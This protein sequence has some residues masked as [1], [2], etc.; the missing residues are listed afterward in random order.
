MLV[1][2]WL[3]AAAP[4]LPTT[5]AAAAPYD[6]AY[7]AESIPSFVELFAPVAVSVTMRNTGTATW[8]R[9]EGDVFL[10]TQRPQDNYYW[11]IQ[12]NPHGM[13]SGNRVLLPHDVAPAAE[14]TFSFVIKPL[15]CGFTAAAPF[16]FRM[17]SQTHGTFG[18]ETPDPGTTV[19]NAA[20]FVSQQAPSIAPAGARIPASVSFRNT[21][22][23]TW[24]AAAGYALASAGPAA[25]TTW[26]R[27]SVPLS[28]DVAPGA[29]ATF[30]FVI[31]VPATPA[32]YNFQWQMSHGANAPF[33]GV[34]PATAIDVV[35]PGPANYQGLWWAAPAGS[36]AGWGIQLAHQGDIVF[37]TWFTYDANGK[38]LWLSM[39]AQKNLTGPFAG[40]YTGAIV[41][42]VGPA[43][44]IPVFP[45]NQVRSVTVGN[46]R[47]AFDDAGGGT[48][49][50]TLN[51][52]AQTKSIVRQ[53]FDLLPTCTFALFNDPALA[54]NYQDLWWA[55]PAGSQSG[56]GV[57]LAHQ[58]DVIFATWF[59]YDHDGSPLWLSFTAP[60]QADGSYA[61]T[62][63]RTTG[64]AF[65][66]NPFAPARVVATDVGTAGL[67]FTSGNAGT[68]T[69]SFEN[70]TRSTPITRQIF[71]SPGTVCQ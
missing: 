5:A 48:F 40:Q 53:A 16:R 13:F 61:G 24:T 45:P 60:K 15:S 9:A 62:L 8:V 58:R 55:S 28:G 22:L 71:V 54:Y 35:T 3:A 43:F 59:T 27:A 12:E 51:G 25:N 39:T 49:A 6:A 1:A 18:E 67:V 30:S 38:A 14:V 46:G 68:F 37:T 10:A 31:D 7:V 20:E 66:A 34:S 47:L 19:S 69:W 26:G 33:G 65:S 29:V 36:E 2:A 32:R 42:S 44:D 70:V 4:W 21:T 56:W 63:Y 50:Y 57:S 11:C 41:Q 64:P 52:V 23:T 17:L